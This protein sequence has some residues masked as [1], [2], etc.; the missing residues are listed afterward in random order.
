MKLPC[1]CCR[2]STLATRSACEVCW[3][4]DDGQDDET[5][6]EVW[7]GLNGAYSLTAARANFKSHGH[8]YDRG[9]GIEAVEMPFPARQALLRYVQAIDDGA[10]AL[11]DV[12]DRLLADIERRRGR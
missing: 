11:D 5:A 7:G 8:M 4:E 6:D 1:P 12:F 3:W 10:V 9:K 2:F